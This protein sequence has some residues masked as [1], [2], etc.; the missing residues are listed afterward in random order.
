LARTGIGTIIGRKTASKGKEYSRIWVYIPT[1]VSEDT[2]FPFQIGAPCMVEINEERK[3]LTVK[4]VSEK[5]ALK[6]G[7]R[8]R[9]RKTTKQL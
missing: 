7:W 6:L 2:A 8:K 4:P 5:E 3:Q 9:N 1:K